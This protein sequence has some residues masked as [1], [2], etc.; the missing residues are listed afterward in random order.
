LIYLVTIF[1]PTPNL[2]GFRFFVGFR[3]IK[4]LDKN[5]STHLSFEGEGSIRHRITK[6]P[7]S[8]KAS[9]NNGQNWT[10]RKVSSLG[11]IKNLP[12]NNSTYMKPV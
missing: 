3:A 9:K 2:P 12:W 8:K 11:G 1:F 7:A 10:V 4:R 5:E 6:L